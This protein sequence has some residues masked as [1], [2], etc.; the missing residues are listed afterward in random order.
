MFQQSVALARQSHT[1]V[2]SDFSGFFAYLSSGGTVF[3][4]SVAVE[5]GQLTVTDNS[6]SVTEILPGDRIMAIGDEPI[7][8]LLPRLISHLAAESPEFA[9][10]LL[11]VYMPLVI[12]LELGRVDVKIGRAHV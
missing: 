4:L 6:S 7:A 5:Q 8:E 12:W 3:P 11:E 2:E 9:Y 1:R 10:V